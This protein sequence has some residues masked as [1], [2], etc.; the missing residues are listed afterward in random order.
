MAKTAFFGVITGLLLAGAAIPVAAADDGSLNTLPRGSYVCGTPGDA[1]G[2]AWNRS[3]NLGFVIVNGSSY[4][5]E[6]GRGTYL[7]TGRS[8]AFTSGPLKGKSFEQETPKRLRS[9][10]ADAGA[11]SLRCYLQSAR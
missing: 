10:A 3:A 6:E 9:V 2:K 7:M 4:R 5:T 8:V 1:S 11:T